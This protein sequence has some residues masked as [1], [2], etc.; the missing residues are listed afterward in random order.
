MLSLSSIDVKHISPK[1]NNHS[2]NKVIQ[3]YTVLH[4]SSFLTLSSTGKNHTQI[5]SYRTLFVYIRSCLRDMVRIGI[6]L[7]GKHHGV[8]LTSAKDNNYSQNR[9]IERYI[10][11]FSYHFLFLA[12][13]L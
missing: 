11:N 3:R 4:S 2:Q 13:W 12:L 8:L 7:K 6:S 9:V 5:K 1:G 10:Y